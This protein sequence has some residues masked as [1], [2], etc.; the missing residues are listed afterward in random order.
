MHNSPR[1]RVWLLAGVSLAAASISAAASAAV[2][3]GQVSDATGVKALQ[4]AEVTIVELGRRAETAPDGSFRFAD[5]PAG[6]YTLRTTYVGASPTETKVTVGSADVRAAIQ[7]GSSAG[8]E[9]ETLLIVG[10]RAN[11]ASS[12]S[13][14]RASDGVESV[15]TRDAVGQFPD[16]NVAEAVRRAPCAGRQCAERPG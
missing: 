16:Q 2:L 8:T 5:V 3:S 7:L 6:T 1:H 15:L 10:Q 14:Q 9:V 4:S 12:L 13:R 11:L